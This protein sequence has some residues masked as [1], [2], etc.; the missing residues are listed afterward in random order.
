LSVVQRLLCP[1]GLSGEE[2][3]KHA[4]D[5]KENDDR[6]EERGSRPAEYA[7]EDPAFVVATF[8]HLSL[9]G[10]PRYEFVRRRK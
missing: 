4:P 6:V 2:E 10:P 9:G 7:G 1:G 5:K 8:A 3:Q